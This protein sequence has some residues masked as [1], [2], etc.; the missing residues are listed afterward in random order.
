MSVL[1]AVGP[2]VFHWPGDEDV[3]ADPAVLADQL[4][5]IGAVSIARLFREF[6]D[7]HIR[8]RASWGSNAGRQ[9]QMKV[10][11]GPEGL[12]VVYKRN[13]VSECSQQMRD[14]TKP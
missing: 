2:H 12:R 6:P 11:P 4:T 14:G 7:T 9:C 13:R 5:E 3:E 8:R 10:P 1:T